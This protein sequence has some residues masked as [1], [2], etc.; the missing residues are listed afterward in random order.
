MNISSLE[1]MVI[2]APDTPFRCTMLPVLAALQSAG[3]LRVVDPLFIQKQADGPATTREVR[4]LS[5]EE[6]RRYAGLADDLMGLVTAGDVEHLIWMIPPGTLAVIA[7]FEHTWALGLTDV[8]RK[9]GGVCFAG[10]MYTFKIPYSRAAGHRTTY[11]MRWLLLALLAGLLSACSP[12]VGA[13]L[14]SAP[15]TALRDDTTATVPPLTATVPPL[16]ATVPPPTATTLVGDGPGGCVLGATFLGDSSPPTGA[17]VAPGAA[18]VK[19]WRVRNDGT[20][21]WTADY[22]LVFIGGDQLGATAG[23]SR[24]HSRARRICFRFAWRRR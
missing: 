15:T 23:V 12:R 11:H 18:L 24:R 8:V 13:G 5:A 19:R 22:A 1:Y 16:T 3:H 14:P 6:L 20:C 7:L 17:L 21:P 10:G 4:D 2:V 9:A